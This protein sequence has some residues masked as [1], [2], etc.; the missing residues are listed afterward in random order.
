MEHT[1]WDSPAR[2]ARG[3][4][5]A[6]RAGIV[7]ALLAGSVIAC[8]APAVADPAAPVDPVAPVAPVA[9]GGPPAPPVRT[10]GPSI[11]LI[12]AP[13][14]PGGLGLLGPSVSGLDPGT[15]LGQHEVPSPPGAGPGTPPNLSIFNNAYGLPQ[16]LEPSAPGQGTQFGVAPGQENANV[17]PREWFGQWIE[18]YRDGRLR[19]GLLGQ[20]PEADLG[21]PLPGTA[22]LP[23]T[24][25]PPG[26]VEY[27]P[28]PAAGP[29]APAPPPA[30]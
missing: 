20:L 14:G 26:L 28:D 5:G 18:M 4:T 24:N 27:L 21:R 17:S 30:G 9:P 10:G 1:R 8:A 6:A 29:P 11:P 12:G 15:I 13:P 7:W 19:G 23:G 22:P 16:Y 2:R 25:L 3:F